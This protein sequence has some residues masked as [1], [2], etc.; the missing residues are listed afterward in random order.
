MLAF[1]LFNFLVKS[2]IKLILIWGFGGFVLYIKCILKSMSPKDLQLQLVNGLA[3][4]HLRV[5]APKL[6]HV[7]TMVGAF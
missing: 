2:Y 4:F 6:H 1:T 3:A 7:I 5:L